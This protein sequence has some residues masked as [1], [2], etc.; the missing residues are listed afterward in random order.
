MVSLLFCSL[1]CSC[2][3]TTL[4]NLPVGMLYPVVVERLSVCRLLPARRRVLK[5]LPDRGGQIEE[6][7]SVG[8][9]SQPA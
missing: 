1:G 2:K 5:V 6:A 4:G 3:P 8:Q 7:V 9:P